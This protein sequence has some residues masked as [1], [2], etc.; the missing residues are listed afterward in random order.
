MR[1]ILVAVDGSAREPVVLA[2]ASELARQVGAKLVLLRAITLPMELPQ[3]AFSS[4]PDEVLALLTRIAREALERR[5][6]DLPGLV[7]NVRVELGAPWSAIC[8]AAREEDVDLI[9]IGSHGYGVLDRLLGTTAAKVVNHAD[10]S[11]FV[12]RR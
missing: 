8:D 6:A 11:V 5:A 4:R 7:E 12:V 2:A 10:R 3:A 9:V 1:K